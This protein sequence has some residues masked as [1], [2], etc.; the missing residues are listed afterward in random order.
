MQI[1][2]TAQQATMLQYTVL[3]YKNLNST[4]NNALIKC[5]KKVPIKIENKGV[6]SLLPAIVFLHNVCRN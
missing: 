1:Y 4:I 5:F 2:Q 3:V 6:N